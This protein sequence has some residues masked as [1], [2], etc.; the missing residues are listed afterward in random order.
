M[1]AVPAFLLSALSASLVVFAVSPAIA[2]ATSTQAEVNSAIARALAFATAQEDPATGEPPGYQHDEIYSGEWLASGYAAAGLSA[3]DVRVGGG[4]SLQD[5]LFG[6]AAGFWDAE[7]LISPET[8]ARLILNAASAGIDTARVSAS[9]NLPA[10][11]VGEWDPASG[12]FGEPSTFSTAWGLAAL[13]TTPLPGW[14]LEPAVSYL[15]ADQHADGGWSFF[16]AAAEEASS[17]DLTAV[18]VGALC[19]AGVPAYDPVVAAGLGYLRGLLVD[20]SGAVEH[21]EFGPNLDT[22]AWTV[23]ALNACGIGPQSSAW[24]T[25]DGKTPVDY[26]L[27]LQL[28]EGG[29]AFAAGEPWFP[30]STGHALRAL[31]GYGFAVGP[32]PRQDPA[33]PTVRPVP[34][35]ATGTPVP[36][37]LAVELAPGNV[38]LCDVTAPVGASL[39][40][41]LAAAQGGSLPRGCVGSFSAAGGEVDEIDGVAPEGADEA[42]LVRLD[43]GAAAVAGR[44]PVGF[45]D[46]VSLWRGPT[47]P[48]APSGAA[49]DP[50]AASAGPPGQAGG[51]GQPGRPGRRGARGKPGRNASIVCKVHHPRPSAPKVRCTVRHRRPGG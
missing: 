34:A 9:Q 15:R 43:R 27:S 5:F 50:A 32:A 2:A 49:T 21:P 25:A 14:S 37:V 17:P 19:G 31:G 28:A 48:A 42:W 35:V 24:T 38:R 4:P 3:A 47:P 41:V 36:H 22:A 13:Q 12:G 29:F 8:A 45:G 46:V 26:I 44:Q 11:L 39:T 7:G 18:A 33:Q 51:A 1:R 23:S 10:E 30:P 6:E 20:E 40:E 16:P